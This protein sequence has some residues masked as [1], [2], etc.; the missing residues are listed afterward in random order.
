MKNRILFQIVMI[1][2]MWKAPLSAQETTFSQADSPQALQWVERQSGRVDSMLNDAMRGS[3]PIEILIRLTDAYQIFDAVAMAGVYCTDVRS[4][5]EAGRRQCDVINYRLEKD[6]NSVLQRVVEARR[7]ARFMK[8]AAK[9]CQITPVKVVPEKV[10]TPNDL[11]VHDAYM[12]ELDLLDG[13]A[14]QDLHILSQKLEH[15]IRALYD[16]EHLAFTLSGC[17]IP[18]RLAESAIMHCQDA[19]GAPNWL[20]LHRSVKS[21]LANV[22]AIQQ[23]AACK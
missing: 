14:T 13:L 15:A 16:V 17:D 8:E 19:L 1:T 7:Q 4:A 6:L 21:A 3:E 9:T 5:A 11:V 20:E 23:S 12:A 10:F 22:Q 18:M 2:W